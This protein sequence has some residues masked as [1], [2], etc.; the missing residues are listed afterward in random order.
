MTMVAA[1]PGA[2]NP[3]PGLRPFRESEASLFFGRERYTTELLRRLTRGRLLTVLGTSASGKSSLV[4]AGFLPVL[5]SGY[6]VSGRPGWRV[7][8]MRPG[9]DPIAALATALSDDD[10]LGARS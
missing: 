9:R 7:A 8:V 6:E 10:V 5:R 3:F 2:L 4:F 1:G